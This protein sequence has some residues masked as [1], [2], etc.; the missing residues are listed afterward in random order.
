[1]KLSKIFKDTNVIIKDDMDIRGIV[2]NS[3]EVKK[4]YLFIAIEG[5][6]RDGHSFIDEAID[7]GASVIVINKNRYNDFKDRN[8]YIIAVNDTRK[9]TSLL[10][11]NF[12]NNPSKDFILIGIT[13]TKG[14]T[15][16]SF[17]IKNILQNAGKKVGLITTVASYINNKKICNNDRTT[18]EPTI[19]QKT[20]DLMRKNNC[21][22]VVMEVSSQ[23]LKLKRVD[24][25][26]F[27]IG[28]FLNLSE[29]HV[30]KNEHSDIFDYFNCKRKLFDM[31]SIGFV[32]IDDKMGKKLISLNKKCKLNLI[33]LNQVNN[34]ITTEKYTIFRC[35]INN[36]IEEIKIPII[37]VH[38][39]YNALFSIRLCEYLM[40]DNFSIKNGLMN[41]YIPGRCEYIS[42]NLNLNIIID[43]AH[44]AK[45]LE[46]I[47]LTIRNISNG[48]IITV[49]GCAGD[50]DKSKR[51]EMGKISGL[52]SNYTFITTDNP[53]NEDPLIICKEIEKGL[54]NITNNYEI[55]ID[56]EEAIKKAI[57][58]ASINDIILLAGK[59][60][61]TYQIIG[62]NKVPFSEKEIINKITSKK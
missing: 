24:H 55:I 52:L 6:I 53:A 11:C 38:N 35:K 33:S 8:A 3:K 28:L 4:G 44:N 26:Y 41:T 57:Y 25:S 16:T 45:S 51:K 2:I 23:S 58:M 29:E 14:K 36:K 20:F 49:F 42:N 10:A 5:Y 40:I 27:D 50:R 31:V 61:E 18:P 54:I 32:N 56:R 39:V 47:L 15:S 7:N 59:G 43:Y 22:Y 48:K 46:S 62:E 1:M 37:G 60:H 34:I 13:G 17:M 9:I 30:S 12:Y 21:E 19:L